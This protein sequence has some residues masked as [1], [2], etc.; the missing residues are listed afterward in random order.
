[1][2]VRADLLGVRDDRDCHAWASAGDWTCCLAP[3][4]VS[5]ILPRRAGSGSTRSKTRR[6]GQH[7]FA[8]QT[9]TIEREVRHPLPESDCA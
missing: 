4:P 8:A 7:S 6:L 2:P 1:M 5:P 3:A 9:F